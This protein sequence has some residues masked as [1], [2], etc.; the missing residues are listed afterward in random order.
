MFHKKL[1]GIGP[2]L[3]PGLLVAFPGNCAP[4]V[5]RIEEGS[6][7]VDGLYVEY[8]KPKPSNGCSILF[9]HGACQSTTYW[10]HFLDWFSHQG[11]NCYTLSLRGHIGSEIPKEQYLNIGIADYAQDVRT[12]A[13]EI[14][15]PLVIIGHSMGGLVSLK[16][17]EGHDTLATVLISPSSP[18]ETGVPPLLLPS[19]PPG[20]LFTKELVGQ[21]FDSILHKGPKESMKL[22]WFSNISD[23]DFERYYDAMCPESPRAFREAASVIEI[24][25][26]KISYPIVVLTGE[27][28]SSH[29]KTDKLI[30]DFYGADYICLRGHS[31]FA[32]CE[33]GWEN[34]AVRIE[35]WLRS[36]GLP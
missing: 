30:A 8:A 17:V 3:V 18:A 20:E 10:E 28:D 13:K 36:Q 29:I 33:N 12:V 32:Q 11:W 5:P 7:K 34:T 9:V 1:R 2:F 22:V 35:R 15:D 25:K 14:G 26:N 24:D 4:G 6:F 31:H 16:Y 21:A 27:L 19:L 23:A